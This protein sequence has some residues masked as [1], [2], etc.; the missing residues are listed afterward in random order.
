MEAFG[1]DR[2]KGQKEGK[3]QRGQTLEGHVISAYSKRKSLHSADF[4]G[5]PRLCKKTDWSGRNGSITKVT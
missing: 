3:M 5:S 1:E 4:F 2:L